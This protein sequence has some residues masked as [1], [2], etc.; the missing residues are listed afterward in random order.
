MS[1]G[2]IICHMVAFLRFS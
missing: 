1:D 2:E